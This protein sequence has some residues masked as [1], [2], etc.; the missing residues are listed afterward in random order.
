MRPGLE[1]FQID[2]N[3]AKAVLRSEGV[4][5]DLQRRANQVKAA[6]QGHTRREL[7][8]D[9]YVGRGRA[10]ATVIGVSETEE[11]RERILGSAIDAA[12]D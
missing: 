10:G 3:G 7:I 9:S 11:A 8:A 1:R 2:S 5:D 4:R 6:A 12:A